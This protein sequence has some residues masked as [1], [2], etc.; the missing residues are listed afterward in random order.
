MEDLLFILYIINIGRFGLSIY[1][2]NVIFGLDVM[3]YWFLYLSH[4]LFPLYYFIGWFES[5]LS[6]LFL[7][8]YVICLICFLTANLLWFL[9]YYE[10][11]IF[12]LIFL[13]CLKSYSGYRIK[14]SFLLFIYSSGSSL[15]LSAVIT[16]HIWSSLLSSI[17]YLGLLFLLS[18]AIKVPMFLFHHW[19]T[20][21]HSEASTALSLI[22]AA[23][24][25]KLGIYAICRYIISSYYLSTQYYIGIVIMSSVIGI[26]IPYIDLFLRL[27]YKILIALSSICHMNMTTV[28]IFSL[29]F[30]GFAAAIIISISHGLNSISLFL[31]AGLLI[32]KSLSHYIDSIWYISMSYRLLFLLIILSNLSIP[33]SLTY[34]GEVIALFSILYLSVI[35]SAV[36]F[37]CSNILSSILSFLF[38]NRVILYC[39]FLFNISI[40]ELF[41]LFFFGI[42]NYCFGSL[43]L[44]YYSGRSSIQ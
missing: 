16:V 11:S 7:F 20:I 13:L 19:L 9:F 30:G 18:L 21:V 33:L 34:I 42:H 28:G 27:D 39:S 17:Q 25:L 15:L 6:I 4:Y 12:C 22:L 2:C 38:F 3:N 24:I 43:F 10:L 29:N 37:L 31:F 35:L 14:S 44:L 5:S 36:I 8:I 1:F 23:L 32:N 26:I 40:V 41:L